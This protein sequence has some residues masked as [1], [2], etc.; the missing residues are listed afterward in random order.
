MGRGWSTV[1]PMKGD[2]GAVDDQR[3]NGHHADAVTNTPV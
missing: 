1:A 2:D 3:G